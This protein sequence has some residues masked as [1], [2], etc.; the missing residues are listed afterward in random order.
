MGKSSVLEDALASYALAY[1]T[2]AEQDYEAF[3]AAARSGRVSVA[4]EI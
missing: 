3:R 4:P 2:Q 1:A